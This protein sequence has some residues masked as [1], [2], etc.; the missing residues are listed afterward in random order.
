MITTAPEDRPIFYEVNVPYSYVAKYI[1]SFFDLNGLQ[2]LQFNIF[3]LL[4]VE[5]PPHVNENLD[6]AAKPFTRDFAS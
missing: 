2:A 1:H 5:I 3:R 6:K 4:S